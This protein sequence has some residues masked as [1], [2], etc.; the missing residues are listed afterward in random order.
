LINTAQSP[1][2][3]TSYRGSQQHSDDK[4]PMYQ[5]SQDASN[6]N[7]FKND[8]QISKAEITRRWLARGDTSTAMALANNIS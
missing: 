1:R 7:W 6:A 8:K 5:T 4:A 3:E 2:V